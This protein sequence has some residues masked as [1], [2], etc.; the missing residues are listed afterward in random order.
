M[1]FNRFILNI[2]IRVLLIV[3]NAFLIAFLFKS[4]AWFFSFLFAIVCLVMQ[5]VLLILYLGKVNTDLAN[6][7]IHLKEQNTTMTSKQNAI[8]RLFGGLSEE[9]CK[10]NDEVKKVNSEK[11]KKQNILNQLLSQVGTGIVIINYDNKIK[12]YNKAF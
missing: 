11:I 5:T 1:G 2:I 10:I 4:E 7:L 3:A 8:D 12:L 9:F 6:F